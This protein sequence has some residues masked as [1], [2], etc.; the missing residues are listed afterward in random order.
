MCVA[1]RLRTESNRL[2]TGRN[3]VNGKRAGMLPT[4]ERSCDRRGPRVTA[5]A[6]HGDTKRRRR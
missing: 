5:A 6:S 1:Y 3:K 4:Y 2:D